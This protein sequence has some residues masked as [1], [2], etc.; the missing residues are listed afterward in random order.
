MDL[1]APEPL[2]KAE[3]RTA[4]KKAKREELN[5]DDIPPKRKKDP[6]EKGEVNGDVKR[7]QKKRNSIWV[8]NLSFKT[9]REL[10]KDF[11]QRGVGEMGGE[12]EGCVTRVNLP[13]KPGHGEFAGNKGYMDKFWEERGAD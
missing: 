7:V 9:T 8:G 6:E 3:I 4:R 1:T 13:K 2:S 5:R 10:L 12:S 11:V